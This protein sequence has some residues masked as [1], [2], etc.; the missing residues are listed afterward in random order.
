MPE[1]DNFVN[2][3]LTPLPEPDKPAYLKEL[4]KDAENKD[5]RVINE[6]G[7]ELIDTFFEPAVLYSVSLNMRVTQEEQFGPVIPIMPFEDINTVF[8]YLEGSDYGQQLSLL[9]NQTEKMGLLIDKLINYVC[10]IN[11]NSQCQCSPDNFPF[12]GRKDSAYVTLSVAD[13][14]NEFSIPT[15]VSVKESVSEKLFLSDI[16]NQKK[17]KFLAN[18][19]IF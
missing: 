12:N 2:Q 17:S 13:A 8:E 1:R 14:L 11:L 16:V 19:C 5:A 7:G 3:F 18:E 10:R 9:G 4:I 15:V 6:E